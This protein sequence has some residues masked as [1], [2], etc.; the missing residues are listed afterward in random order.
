MNTQQLEKLDHHECF[1]Q[2]QQTL[3]NQGLLLE[4]CDDVYTIRFESSKHPWMALPKKEVTSDSKEQLNR[5]LIMFCL[6]AM[7]SSEEDPMKGI[8]KEIARS[9]A[10]GFFSFFVFLGKK[11]T[12]IT[13]AIVYVII[14]LFF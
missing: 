11:K 4:E 13:I 7:Q 14:L 8:G 3:F 5:D 2:L 1:V 12:I 10:E 9:F 6:D